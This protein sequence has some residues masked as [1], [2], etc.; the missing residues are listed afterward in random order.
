M[1]RYWAKFRRGYFWFPYFWSIP[2]NPP[3]PQN[4]PLKSP[5]R[6]GL[7]NKLL[8]NLENRKQ[9]IIFYTDHSYLTLLNRNFSSVSRKLQQFFLTVQYNLVFNIKTTA[10][11]FM[12]NYVMTVFQREK[13]LNW[14]LLHFTWILFLIKI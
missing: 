5:P 8:P 4:K 12:N 10:L 13:M 7:Q 2:Y 3:S 14:T 9:L 1:S 6:L 11:F